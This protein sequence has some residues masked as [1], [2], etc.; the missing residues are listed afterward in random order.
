[1][2]MVIKFCDALFLVMA[3]LVFLTCFIQPLNRWQSA[4][5]VGMAIGNFV[6]YKI[7]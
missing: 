4:C 7:K 6:M 5:W 2:K 1:M 3:V